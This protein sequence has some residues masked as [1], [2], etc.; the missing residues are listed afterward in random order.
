[1]K[2]SNNMS[3]DIVKNK[4]D[5]NIKNP[6]DINIK[7]LIDDLELLSTEKEKEKFINNYSRL[8]NQ[9]KLVDIELNNNDYNLH[10]ENY[11][12]NELFKILELNESK[13]FGSCELTLSDLIL[14]MKTTNLLE[15]KIEQD[16]LDIIELK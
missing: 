6:N 11:D 10:L 8:N 2:N 5:V 15:K 1:M 12:I 14:L 16:T 13:I 3:K 7:K 9:I 4:N